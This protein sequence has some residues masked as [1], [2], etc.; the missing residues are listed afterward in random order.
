MQ[1]EEYQSIPAINATAIKAGLTSMRHM[2]AV[3]T[4]KPKP[5]TPAMR[6][7][8]L[9]HKA[10]LEPDDF[11]V[12]AFVWDGATKRGKAFD[13]FLGERNKFWC[14]TADEHAELVAIRE[15]VWAKGAAYQL[16]EAAGVEHEKS[17]T[18]DDLACGH[19]KARIDI[20]TPYMICDLKT[21]GQIDPHRFARTCADLAYHVQLGF[22]ARA[23]Q[24]ATGRAELPVVYIIAVESQEPYDVTVYRVPESTVKAGETRALEIACEYRDCETRGS[25]PG[26]DG[27]DVLD[28]ELPSWADGMSEIPDVSGIPDFTGC[29]IGGD[30]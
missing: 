15:A 14:L 2:H 18:W 26:V 1:F 30:L 6:W 24:Q 7:G 27:G 19:C 16:I 22:Y 29:E 4:G 5:T 13:E 23:I 28:L 20:A 17:V 11:D 21:T 9:V 3:M 8:T 10:V 12:K 25:F